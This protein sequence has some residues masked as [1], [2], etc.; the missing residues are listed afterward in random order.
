[1]WSADSDDGATHISASGSVGGSKTMSVGG[2]SVS[3]IQVT[4]T[5][6]ISGDINGTATL[7]MWVSPALRLPVVQRQ[8]INATMSS[9]YG[10]SNRFSSDV[11][12]TLTSL[13]PT[14]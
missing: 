1:S 4:T 11:T 13:T 5:L 10:L 7:T 6:S 3:L 9:G 8:V 2:Q 12:Q 14:N